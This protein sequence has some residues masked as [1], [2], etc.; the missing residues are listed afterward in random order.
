MSGSQIRM[1]VDVHR[2]QRSYLLSTYARSPC[3]L[4]SVLQGFLSSVCQ[5]PLPFALP[6]T[7]AHHEILVLVSLRFPQRMVRGCY[8]T[9]RYGR[10]GGHSQI[11]PR[12]IRGSP[13]LAHYV[14]QT[15]PLLS[16]DT[17]P[18]ERSTLPA[19]LTAGTL[20]LGLSDKVFGVINSAG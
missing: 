15:R 12:F 14:P 13:H 19:H 20:R 6:Q 10:A 17:F 16:S 4:T 3:V 7:D 9:T 11:R 18:Q 8:P 1:T 2:F 5:T